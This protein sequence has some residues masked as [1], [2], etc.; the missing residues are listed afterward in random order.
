MANFTH[1]VYRTTS[2][3]IYLSINKLDSDIKIGKFDAGYEKQKFDFR[4]MELKN[5][6]IADKTINGWFYDGLLI[7]FDTDVNKR[8]V[9]KA[10]CIKAS[11]D[12]IIY[13][14][15]KM[16]WRIGYN[17][18]NDLVVSDATSNFTQFG[19][20]TGQQ[21]AWIKNNWACKVQ[22]CNYGQ[23]ITIKY[24]MSDLLKHL[25]SIGD[26][27]ITQLNNYDNLLETAKKAQKVESENSIETVK[28]IVSIQQVKSIEKVEPIAPVE[29]TSDK[30]YRIAFEYYLQPVKKLFSVETVLQNLEK[31]T[32]KGYLD[33]YYNLNCINIATA[34]TENRGDSLREDLKSII[35]AMYENFKLK[36]EKEGISVSIKA[37][38][39]TYLVVEL[40][41]NP[42]INEELKKKYVV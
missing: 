8:F 20:I 39:N 6:E 12:S 10:N 29:K 15:Y 23:I 21:V 11:L 17:A 28:P 27:F 22:L 4:Y 41:Q 35:V 34:F 38:D 2:N 18:F 3:D 7:L 24:R 16:G 32:A 36:M 33:E 9:G 5:E 40:Q 31:R 1:Y 42:T 19:H 26:I 25:N 37:A 13:I 30:L 14:I